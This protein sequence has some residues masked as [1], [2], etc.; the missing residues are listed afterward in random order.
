[1]A[2]MTWRQDQEAGSSHYICPEEAES[3]ECMLQLSSPLRTESWISVGMVDRSKWMGL[4]TSLNLIQIT[5]ICLIMTTVY[6][7]SEAKETL[8]QVTYNRI[9]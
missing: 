3:N 6:K 5:S 8:G 2:G 1:M 4:S 9:H 7:I